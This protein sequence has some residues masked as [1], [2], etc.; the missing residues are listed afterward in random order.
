MNLHIQ[1][2]EPSCGCVGVNLSSPII[3]P[4]TES[5]VSVSYKADSVAG[6]FTKFID[7]FVEEKEAP[8]RFVISGYNKTLK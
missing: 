7:I 4:K 5:V 1:S 3:Y 6:L 8:Y 2:V